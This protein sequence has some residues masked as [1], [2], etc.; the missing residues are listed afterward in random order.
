MKIIKVDG[1]TLYFLFICFLCG[2]IKVALMIF[3]IVVIHEFGHLFFIKLLGY[4]VI[5]VKIYP[6]GGITKVEKDINTPIGHEMLIALGGVLAQGI[7]YGVMYSDISYLDKELFWKYNTS[8]LLFNLLPIIPLDGSKILE[9]VLNRMWSFKVSYKVNLVVSLISLV[10]F[11]WFNYKYSLNNYMVVVFLLFKMYKYLM[12]EKFIYNR[13]LLE[14]YLNNY[15]FRRIDTRRG[16]LNILK[17][18]V[19]QYF[20]ED[21]GAVSEKKKLA[22]RFDKRC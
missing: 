3:A 22:I 17:K 8:I 19:Y 2:Y 9:C 12:D 16:N 18:D 7:L 5:E 13:F 21:E 10:L 14:R 1:W 20:L 15:R 11:V 6:F 4:K